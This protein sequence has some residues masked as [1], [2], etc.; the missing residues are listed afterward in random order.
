MRTTCGTMWAAEAGEVQEEETA[1]M[2]VADFTV[3]KV[4]PRYHVS[5]WRVVELSGRY[6]GGCECGLRHVHEVVVV[7]VHVDVVYGTQGV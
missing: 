1:M 2:R 3:S 6:C 4:T 5:Y 7:H